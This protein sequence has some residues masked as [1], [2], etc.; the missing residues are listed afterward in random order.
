[1]RCCVGSEFG[2]Q[3]IDGRSNTLNAGGRK[4][5]EREEEA[6]FRRRGL[7]WRLVVIYRV[8]WVCVAARIDMQNL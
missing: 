5:A 8:D 3:S 7:E 2:F 4:M 6:G 1:M